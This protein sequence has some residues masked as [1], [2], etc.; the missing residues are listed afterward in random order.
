MAFELPG[1]RALETHGV[2]MRGGPIVRETNARAL[3]GDGDASTNLLLLR[4]T[5][6]PLRAKALHVKPLRVQGLHP[7]V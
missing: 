4:N 7:Q 3:P 6:M 1:I 2:A 5:Q